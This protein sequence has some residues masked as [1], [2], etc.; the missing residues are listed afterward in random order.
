MSSHRKPANQSRRVTCRCRTHQCCLGSFVDA[1]GNTQ[2]GVEVWPDTKKAHA[3]ADELERL[4]MESAPELDSIEPSSQHPFEAA[5]SDDHP[6]ANQPSSAGQICSHAISAREHGVEPF[7]CGMFLNV[8]VQFNYK[9]CT[10][11]YV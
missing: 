10:P 8:I 1:Y 7:Q 6:H 5:P 3:L 2:S 9:I 4:S 11:Q